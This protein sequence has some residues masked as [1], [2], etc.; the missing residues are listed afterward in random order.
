MKRRKALK[1]ILGISLLT[2]TNA[3]AFTLKKAGMTE[4]GKKARK[5]FTFAFFTDVHLLRNNDRNSHIGFQRALDDVL[6]KKVDFILF[7]GDN[8]DAYHLEEAEADTLYGWFKNEVDK[9]GLKAYYAIGNHDAFYQPKDKEADPNSFGLFQKYFGKLYYSFDYKGIHFIILNSV[10]RQDS[11]YCVGA[12]QRQWLANHLKEIGIHVP[13]V[14]AMH[15]PIQSLYGPAVEGKPELVDNLLDYKEVWEILEP[16]NIKLILQGHQHIYEELF[17]KD[18]QFL[19]GGAVCGKWWSA[20]DYEKTD[21]GY[22]LI[23]VDKDNNFSWEYN[24][25]VKEKDGKERWQ[26]TQGTSQYDND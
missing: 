23:E 13:I 2:A 1:A 5:K 18:T 8:V 6:P 11:G 17:V 15:V 22:M 9:R 3:S 4:E 20:G 12:E 10:N 25:F 19:T 24:A 21:K 16:Y 14:V 7:G 26:Y